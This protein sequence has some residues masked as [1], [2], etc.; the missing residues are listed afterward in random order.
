MGTHDP[1]SDRQSHVIVCFSGIHEEM[2]KKL[3]EDIVRLHGSV[4]WN[5]AFDPQITHLVALPNTRTMKTLI[6][7]VLGKWLVTTGWVTDS[8]KVGYFLPEQSY[9]T[10]FSPRPFLGKKFFISTRFRKKNKKYRLQCCKTLINLGAGEIVVTVT[11][12]DYILVTSKELQSSI[13]SN[14]TKGKY[15]VWGEFI[16]LINPSSSIV[17]SPSSLLEKSM[18]CVLDNIENLTEKMSNTLTLDLKEKLLDYAS[19]LPQLSSQKLRCLLDT[20]ISRLTLCNCIDLSKHVLTMISKCT[21]LVELNLSLEA[22][23][24]NNLIVSELSLL[25]LVQQLPK[26]RVLNVSRWHITDV[27]LSVF[28]KLSSLTQLNLSYCTRLTSGAL[29]DFFHQGP[30]LSTINLSGLTSIVNDKV[31]INLAECYNGALLRLDV[32]KCAV[33]DRGLLK[34][35]HECS[36]LT[37]LRLKQTNVTFLSV[38]YLLSQ[39]RELKVISARLVNQRGGECF[40]S[41]TYSQTKCYTDDVRSWIFNIA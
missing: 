13:T 32:S 14:N 30:I 18:Q 36:N 10:K 6:A 8:V 12:A 16:K 9:G 38:S 34:V 39:C 17:R 25:K 7:S 29:I 22:G 37:D 2:K 28:T 31:V 41:H 3:S 11:D 23:H 15:L 27:A 21:E 24:E 4:R 20:R 19:T 33:S 26:L 5:S 40:P 35:A 1:Q